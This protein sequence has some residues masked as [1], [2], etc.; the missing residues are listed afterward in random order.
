MKVERIMNHAA[1]ACAASDSLETAAAIMWRNDCGCVPVI[2][3]DGRAIGMI[4]D[5]DICMAALL[6]GGALHQLTVASAMATDVHTCTPHDTVAD[7][8]SI[9]RDH[10]LRRLPVVDD[11]GVL[12]G[13]LS[14]NDIAL[15]AK[16]KRGAQDIGFAELGQTM[17]AICRPRPTRALAM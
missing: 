11:A 14:L 2:D 8:E 5:R 6:Q 9:M 15:Q 13:I 17:A 3:T 7:A 12:V 1:Y 4:T 16:T 10:Q